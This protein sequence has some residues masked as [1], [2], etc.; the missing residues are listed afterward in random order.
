MNIA[1][2]H[3]SSQQ[4][5]K[6][7]WLESEQDWNWHLRDAELLGDNKIKRWVMSF[8][9]WLRRKSLNKREKILILQIKK[10]IRYPNPF[11][12][13]HYYPLK[14]KSWEEGTLKLWTLSTQCS[15]IGKIENKS[16]QV[17]IRL[18]AV[19]KSPFLQNGRNW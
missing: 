5:P 6:R 1:L 8:V 4:Q 13:P 12:S 18:V 2:G 19:Q 10:G 16:N 14:K 9:N 11:H 15:G 17:H 7:K 3:G